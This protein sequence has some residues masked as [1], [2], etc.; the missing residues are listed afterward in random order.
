MAVTLG[1]DAASAQ[2]RMP[3]RARA[4]HDAATRECIESIS[5]IIQQTRQEAAMM[6]QMAADARGAGQNDLAAAYD[7]MAAQHAGH[8][9]DQ[10]QVLATYGARPPA[11]TAMS[12]GSHPFDLQHAITMH[13]ETEARYNEAIRTERC[14]TARRLQRVL[15]LCSAQHAN[16]LRAMLPA[17]PV[18]AAQPQVVYVDRVVERV[19][20]RPVDR[21]VERVVERPVD[22]VVERV[23]ERERI[24]YRDRPAPVRVRMRRPAR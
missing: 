10:I 19:V 1:P 16:Q 4:V 17:P 13:S 20:E 21:V 15:A 5:R 9:E 14:A 6:R 18:V 12:G 23:V 22:R 2:R 24:V 11:E 8:V 3:M 7:R